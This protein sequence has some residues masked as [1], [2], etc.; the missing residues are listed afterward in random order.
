MGKGQLHEVLAVEK[1]LETTAKKVI[2]EGIAT[3]RGKPERFRGV[4]KRYDPFNEE[5]AHLGGETD[6]LELTTTVNK[7]LDYVFRHIAKYVDAVYQKD[8][9]N[10]EAKADVVIDGKVLLEKAPVT[11]LLGLETKL[12]Q[13]RLLLEA[14]PTLAPGVKW[15]GAPDKGDDVYEREHPEEKFRT[16]LEIKHKVLYEATKEH[17][18]QIEKYTEQIPVGKF[19]QYEWSGMITPAQKSE[20]LGRLDKLMRAVKKA[21]MRANSTEVLGGHIGSTLTNYI[22]KG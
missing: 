17:P 6:H 16:K 15:K 13:W 14:I 9:T 3:L 5:E 7:K 19:T 8:V 2:E 10:C 22:L 4:V 12:K 11:T 1:G 21:R 18:A 20:L